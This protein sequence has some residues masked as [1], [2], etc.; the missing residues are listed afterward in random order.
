MK[1]S[2]VGRILKAPRDRAEHQGR[3]NKRTPAIGEHALSFL[4]STITKV[5][6]ARGAKVNV[7]AR[8]DEVDVVDV[9]ATMVIITSNKHRCP[10]EVFQSQFPSLPTLGNR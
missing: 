5:V 4:T 1:Q 9:V 3:V 8:V 6:V 7:V 10:R 2:L